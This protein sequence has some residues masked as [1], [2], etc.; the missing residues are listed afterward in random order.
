[1]S[2]ARETS[3]TPRRAAVYARVSSKAQA[4]ADK[5]SIFEQFAE[6]ENY[7]K[8]QRYEIVQRYQDVASGSTKKRPDFQRLLRD[9]R[10]GLFDVIICWKADRLSRGI[11]PAAVLMEVVEAHQIGLESVTDTLDMKTFGIYAAVG[12]IENRQFPRARHVG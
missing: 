9:A 10:D 12:K 8:T 1:M 5:V 6:M 11:Y 2:N 4:E 3:Q 7:C